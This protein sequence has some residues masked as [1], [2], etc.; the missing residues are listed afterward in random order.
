ME[1]PPSTP[2]PAPE[3]QLPAKQDVITPPSTDKDKIVEA[4][5]SATAA[6]EQG[7]TVAIAAHLRRALMLVEPNSESVPDEPRADATRRKN[8]FNRF[9]KQRTPGTFS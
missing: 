9:R 1:T 8:G 5:K 6:A 2:L 4:C 7:D 3:P